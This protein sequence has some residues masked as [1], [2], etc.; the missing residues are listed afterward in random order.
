MQ[1]LFL[2]EEAKAATLV[3]LI[4]A[5]RTIWSSDQSKKE[6]V[7]LRVFNIRLTPTGRKK[8]WRKVNGFFMK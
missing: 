1:A 5:K 8:L 2:R 6:R 7:E 3:D 4:M